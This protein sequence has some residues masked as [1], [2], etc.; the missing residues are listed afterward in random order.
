L[1]SGEGGGVP[2]QA[3]YREITEILRSQIENGTLARGSRLPTEQ[4]LQER[5]EASRNT[6]RDA[7]KLL[8]AMGLVVTRPGSG[9]F[10]TNPIDPFVTILTAHPE[11]GFGGGEGAAY[12]SEV[13]DEHRRPSQSIPKVE[14]LAP[15]ADIARR[16]RIAPGS[17]V[18]SRQ[19]ARTI[20]DTPWSRQISFYPMDFITKGATKLLMADDIPQGVIAYLADQLGIRQT[21]Y[22]DWVTARAPDEAEMSF[23]GIGPETMVFVV[24]RTAFDQEQ[25]PMRLTVTAY[26]ADRN[27]FIYEYGYVPDPRYEDEDPDAATA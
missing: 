15:P 24:Y 18:V 11:T 23:F 2:Q 7:V 12:L 17:M 5:F 1:A 21:G 8:A 27:Q 26:P 25:I 19:Q 13:S 3:R 16:L 10:V 9:T 6:V 22:R 14:V 4:E 20:D